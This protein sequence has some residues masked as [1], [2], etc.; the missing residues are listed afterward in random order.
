M[1]IND[2]RGKK[3]PGLFMTAIPFYNVI[4]MAFTI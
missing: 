4:Y 2:L 1:V 3:F